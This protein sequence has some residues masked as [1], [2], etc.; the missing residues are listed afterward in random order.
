MGFSAD[1]PTSA[2]HR[3]D[4][5]RSQRASASRALVLASRSPRREQLLANSGYTFEVLVPDVDDSHL[6]RGAVDPDMWVQ[7]LAYFKAMAS[8]HMINPSMSVFDQP[9]PRTANTL[10]ALHTRPPVVL[11]ADTVC[12]QNNVMLGKPANADEAHSMMRAFSGASH[13]VLTGVALLDLDTQS[14]VM[15]TGHSRVYFDV[16]SEAAIDAY[17]ASNA[18][19]GKAGAYNLAERLD[20]GWNIDIDGDPTNVVGLPM[21]RVRVELALL[22]VRPARAEQST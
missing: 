10:D 16:L 21:E 20:D 11:G 1:I 15:F 6:H 8:A 19:Q 4:S 5:V 14:R 18:W 2:G 17:V 13:D 3:P 9:I 7:A 12:V 22:G